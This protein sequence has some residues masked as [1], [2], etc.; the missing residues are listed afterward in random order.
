M[1]VSVLDFD[2]LNFE[3]TSYNYSTSKLYTVLFTIE[4]SKRFKGDGVIAHVV[5]PGI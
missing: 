3:K 2:N 4:L 1:I 5:H